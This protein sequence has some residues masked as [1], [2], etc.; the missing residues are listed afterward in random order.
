MIANEANS[1]R[2]IRH[3]TYNNVSDWEI[4]TFI[5]RKREGECAPETICSSHKIK[6][7]QNL[8][9]FEIYQSSSSGNSMQKKMRQIAFV[10]AE[11]SLLIVCGYV[12]FFPFP[13]ISVQF[14]K[15][16]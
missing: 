10:S 6:S 9:W 12:R 11:H 15:S 5:G 3:R 4:K 7:A 8:T 1:V 16:S 13:P 2:H 14:V